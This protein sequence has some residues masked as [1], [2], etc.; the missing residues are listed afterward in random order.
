MNYG[1]QAQHALKMLEVLR[2]QHVQAE[3]P[4]AKKPS[5]D[6]LWPDGV[7]EPRVEFEPL[8]M[9]YDTSGQPLVFCR[10]IS[11]EVA[12]MLPGKSQEPHVMYRTP[13]DYLNRFTMPS[14]VKTW[15]HKYGD[16]GHTA[17]SL[18]AMNGDLAGFGWGNVW[19]FPRRA[20]FLEAA[21][22]KFDDTQL[23]ADTME[24]RLYEGYRRRGLAE[25]FA[26]AIA[27]DYANL[28]MN[29]PQG[30]RTVFRGLW[31]EMAQ[32]N[33]RAREICANLD[34][35]QSTRHEVEAFQEIVTHNRRTVMALEVPTIRTIAAVMASRQAREGINAINPMSVWLM[36][37]RQ[38]DA[39]A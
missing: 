30:K 2:R 3:Q 24:F 33:T 32:K 20:P 18:L 28:R 5:T 29:G 39:A 12:A 34:G 38:A 22:Q 35:I 4:P 6:E 19:Q 31:V 27:V 16:D 14:T 15:H 26:G 11:N 17:Y 25:P 36:L 23:P 13:R 37:Q 7:S 9:L 1:E 8:R 10:G 21:T